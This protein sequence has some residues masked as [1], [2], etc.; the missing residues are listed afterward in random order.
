MIHLMRLP[1][2]ADVEVAVLERETV[3]VVCEKL[4]PAPEC[5]IVFVVRFLGV[6]FHRSSLAVFLR[7]RRSTSKKKVRIAN[8]IRIKTNH[9]TKKMCVLGG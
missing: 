5:A 8:I 7:R 2:L 3:V 1:E 9:I 6:W 4:F